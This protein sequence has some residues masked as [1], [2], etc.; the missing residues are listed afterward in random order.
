MAPYFIGVDIGTAGTKAAIVDTDGNVLSTAYEESKLYY[1]RVGWVEQEPEDF[2]TSSINT[3][4]EA[5]KKSKIDPKEVVSLAFSGQMAGILA[6][7]KNWN[8]VIRYDSWLDIR[9]KD[10]V[11]YLSEHYADMLIEIGGVPP[12]VNHLPKMM[13][14][15]DNEPETFKR[16]YKFT[17]PAVYAAG[18]FAGLRGD[19]A[20]YDYT[21]ATFTGMFDIHKMEWSQEIADTLNIPLDKLPKIV[22]PWEIIGELTPEM[23]EKCGLIKGIPI[24]AGAGDYIASCLGAGLTRPGLCID[25]AGTASIISVST[26]KIAPDKEHKTLLYVKS[27]VPELWQVGAYINGGGLCLRWFRD[28]F[29][30]YEK[31]RAKETNV[32]PYKLLD[33]EASKIPEGSEGLIFIPH[34]GGRAYPNQPDIKGVWFGFTWKHTIGHFFRSIMEGIAY[35][36]YYYMR[37][38]KSLFKD[39]QFEEIRGIGGGSKSRIWS[40]IKADVLNIPYILLNKEEYAALALAAIGGYAVGALK[41]YKQAIEKWVKPVVRIDPRPEKH[42][43]YRKYAEFYEQLLNSAN[44]IFKEHAKLL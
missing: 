41:D 16:I 10:Y 4:R 5:L 35:E 32:D 9:C 31:E 15:R 1:P 39:L 3:I 21:Y 18:K 13:W 30:K 23:A 34:L 24:A 25:V 42:E 12:T 40:Q 17:V 20:F 22:K 37:I 28:E 27:V 11:S 36:Y 7:D 19:D 38:A 14:W 2:V 44:N 26:D 6:I 43:I 8:P 33:E 29:G